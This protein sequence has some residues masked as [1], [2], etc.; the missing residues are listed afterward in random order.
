MR[1]RG[2]G[3]IVSEE[4]EGDVL[5]H[6]SVLRKH[7]RRSV[8]EGAIVECVPVLLERGLQAKKVLSID[9]TS[10]LPTAAA[11]GQRWSGPSDRKA[12]ATRPR[13]RAGGGQ[14]V[15]SRSWLW[16]RVSSERR[17]EAQDVFV[18]METVRQGRLGEL[19]PGQ[20]LEVKIAPS[21]KGLTAMSSN[22][23][24]IWRGRPRAR[25]V[26]SAGAGAK[27]AGTT[28]TPDRAEAGAADD[29]L[30]HRRSS[31]HSRCCGHT[32]AAAARPDV[33]PVARAGPGDGFSLRPPTGHRLL[34]EEYAHPVGHGLHS[35][36]P[37]DRAH[38]GEHDTPLAGPSAS[39][40]PVALVLEIRGGRAA[41]LGVAR[42]TGW[43]GAARIPWS[44][45]PLAS[46]Q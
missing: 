23:P 44:L 28:K 31:F 41:E 24:E 40:E 20:M 4:V 11:L 16:F 33:R 46:S 25:R 37:N 30:F 13:V 22:C 12:L 17:P 27:S 29:P 9:L 6:F 5:L 1:L 36:G 35:S 39:G 43:S 14:M 21:D 10:A 42:A 32:G 38:C 45:R 19:Q 7:G 2:F 15:Q 18:H 26:Q 8:P 3:F 34:D